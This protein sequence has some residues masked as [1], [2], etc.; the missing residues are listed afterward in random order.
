MECGRTAA[1]WAG[2]YTLEDAVKIIY[3]SSRLQESTGGIGRMVAVGISLE[4]AREAIRGFE[5]QVAVAA[6]NSPNLV[7]LAGDTEA[8]EA[9]V[10][11]LET[12][13]VFIRWLPI[14]YAF[15]THQMDPIRDDLL[16]SLADIKPRSGRIPFISTVTG[17]TIDGSELDAEYWWRNVRDPVKFERG[18][19]K[20]IDRGIGLFLELGPHPI[21]YH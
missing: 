19:A 1:Y 15:H 20:I 18:V 14:D 2:V 6:V 7:T 21:P 12:E 13:E 8:V 5:N 17:S 4:R 3:H 16:K 11:A 10:E 9:V